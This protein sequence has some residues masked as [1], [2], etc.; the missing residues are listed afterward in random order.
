MDRRMDGRYTVYL[1]HNHAVK[2][3]LSLQKRLTQLL[4]APE[5]LENACDLLPVVR[6]NIS[7]TQS[8]LQQLR[9]VMLSLFATFFAIHSEIITEFEMSGIKLTSKDLILMLSVIP[10]AA[11]YFYYELITFFVARRIQ[12]ALHEQ[13]S[14]R[15][16]PA[17]EQNGLSDF[18]LPTSTYVI[19]NIL[20]VNHSPNRRWSIFMKDLGGAIGVLTILLPLLF[21]IYAAIAVMYKVF[22][23]TQP[24]GFW[25]QLILLLSVPLVITFVS[26]ALYMLRQ[27]RAFLRK[28]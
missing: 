2:P 21:C 12:L 3:M 14:A 25:P 1:R 4:Q 23:G 15:C 7:D 11:A 10:V 18:Y 19:N 22:S 17:I 27:T 28:K 13:L 20:T 8:R 5:N 16:L 26:N 24:A 6:N 9:V